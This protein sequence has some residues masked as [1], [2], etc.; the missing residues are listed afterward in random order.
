M[1]QSH[2]LQI[3]ALLAIEPPAT[4]G[5][6]DLRDAMA[7]VLRASSIKAALHGTAPAGPAT[8]RAPSTGG[9]SPTTPRRRAWTRT[10][11]PRPSPRCTWTSTTGA[12]RTCRSSSAPA[13]R[14][15]ASARRPWSRSGR[16]RT[17]PE[18]FT[19]WDAPNKLRI[20]FGPD[21]L[22]STSTSTGP[23]DIFSLDRAALEA[24]LNASELLPYG[25]VLEGVLTGDP[26]LSVR[27]DTAED[28]WRIVEPVLAAWAR[29]KFR[30]RNTAGT[31]PDGPGRFVHSE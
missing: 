24:E 19:G 30:W 9:T 16:C 17:F 1:I 27:G 18:G 31:A 28:C 14:W 7:T 15:A 23:G 22:S 29:G 11:T 2:L 12:G 8:R 26:L 10:G 21:T 25:E 13:R 5:E 6:R 3:M 20:G 4:I